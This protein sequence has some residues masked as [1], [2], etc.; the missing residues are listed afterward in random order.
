VQFP[1]AETPKAGG[2]AA[3]SRRL[4]NLASPLLPRSADGRA[5]KLRVAQGRATFLALDRERRGDRRRA[6]RAPVPKQAAA[7]RTGGRKLR[8]V[9]E[10]IAQRVPA[11]EA[12]RDP[13]AERLAPLLLDPV[14]PGWCHAGTVVLSRCP[15]AEARRYPSTASTRRWSE[16]DGERSSF[17]KILLTCLSTALS[18]AT[19]RLRVGSAAARDGS[20]RADTVHAFTPDQ[21]ISSNGST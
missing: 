14:P 21:E 19:R 10:E 8:L 6:R 7:L 12:E 16:S 11:G 5:E 9:V 18:W 13:V 17:S 4:T 3:R 1:I 20:G 15:Q 2:F